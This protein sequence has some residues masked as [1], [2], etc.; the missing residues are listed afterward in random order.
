MRD[1][2]NLVLSILPVYLWNRE[3]NLLLQKDHWMWSQ[4]ARC[5]SLLWHPLPK[6]TGICPVFVHC[7]FSREAPILRSKI[8]LRGLSQS[9][10][11]WM[12]LNYCT[13]NQRQP[14]SLSLPVFRPTCL[15][16]HLSVH[17]STHPPT[18]LPIHPVLVQDLLS[19]STVL[20]LGPQERKKTSVVLALS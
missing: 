8:A 11:R 10:E 20:T 5:A 3:S 7:F 1:S 19:T 12:M 17:P 6:Q 9:K 4:N 13:I 14:Y 15:P 2:W 18:H 16:D